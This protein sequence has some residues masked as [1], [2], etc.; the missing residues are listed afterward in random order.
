VCFER[1]IVSVYFELKRLAKC[2]CRDEGAHDL[3]AE[4]VTR[5]LEHREC[6]DPSR[7]LLSWCRAIMRNL[8]INAGCRLENV[9]TVRMGDEDCEGGAEP[10]V[11]TENNELLKIIRSMCGASVA[12]ETLLEFAQ[13]YSLAEIAERRGIPL[14]TVKRRIHDGRAML[15]KALS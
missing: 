12:V 4:A 3:A 5:A 15:H 2:Y 9:N 6:Y 8:W 11:V 10:D 13:G 14:G 7:P 1:D